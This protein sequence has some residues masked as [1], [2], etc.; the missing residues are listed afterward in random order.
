MMP[1]AT[2][3]RVASRGSVTSQFD[4][5]LLEMELSCSKQ[6]VAKRKASSKAVVVQTA[7]ACGEVFLAGQLCGFPF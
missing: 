2:H 3:F 6:H 4:D 1:S 7:R 5:I